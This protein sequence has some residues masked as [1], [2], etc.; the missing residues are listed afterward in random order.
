LVSNHTASHAALKFRNAEFGKEL[1]DNGDKPVVKG[2]DDDYYLI[3]PGVAIND[4][5]QLLDKY[6]A[7]NERI[8]VMAV[9]LIGGYNPDYSGLDFSE[10]ASAAI[11]AAITGTQLANAS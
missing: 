3:V 4:S 2:Y 10:A 6:N 5:F 9:P 7:I 8:Y 11:I 1:L